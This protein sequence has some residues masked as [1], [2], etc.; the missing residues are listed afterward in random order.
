MSFQ[1]L[2]EWW[3]IIYAAPLVVSLVWIVVTVLSGAHADGS[4]G[5]VHAAG[6]H[7]LTHDIGHAA[8]HALHHGDAGVDGADH[9]Q[10]SHDAAHDHAHGHDHDGQQDSFLN[11]LLLVLGFGTVPITLIFGIFLLCWGAFGLVTNRVLGGILVYPAVYVWP[12]IGITFVVSSLFTRMSAA[13]IGRFMPGTE[14]FGV[15]RF[16]MIG[17]IGHAVYAVSENAGTVNISDTYGTVHR[18]QAKTEAGAESIPSGAEVIAVD[19]DELDKR[20]VVRAS[21]F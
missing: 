19:F 8:S 14:T 2:L 7:G 17:S 3:N 6:D 13:V 5:H 21:N 9:A 4:H 20:F 12:S 11:R 18:V 1:S 16:E 15:T 10:A